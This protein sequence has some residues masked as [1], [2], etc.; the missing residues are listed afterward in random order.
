MG[1]ESKIYIVNVLSHKHTIIN[2]YT[3]A[4]FGIKTENQ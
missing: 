4:P 3:Q 2:P 1:Y